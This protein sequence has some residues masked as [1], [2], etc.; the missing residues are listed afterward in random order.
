[1]ADVGEIMLES[2]ESVADI[3]SLG[4]AGDID[5]HPTVEVFAKPVSQRE[6]DIPKVATIEE[7]SAFVALSAPMLGYGDLE[8]R[9]LGNRDGSAHFEIGFLRCQPVGSRYFGRLSKSAAQAQFGDAK[10]Q[11]TE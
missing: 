1:M 7:N 9:V 5:G 10:V 8:P 4:R 6:M 2:S 3:R 11:W